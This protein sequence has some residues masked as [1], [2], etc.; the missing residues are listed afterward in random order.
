MGDMIV[1]THQQLQCMFTWLQTFNP[2]LGL[3]T[4]E[5]QVVSI[6]RNGLIEWRQI[7]IDDQMM[8]TDI[9]HVRS[10]RSHTRTT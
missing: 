9:R 4:T 1:V 2:Y 7:R 6:G 8:V 5:V 3:S 10:F